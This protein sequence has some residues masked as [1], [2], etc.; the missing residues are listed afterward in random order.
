MKNGEP[1]GDYEDFLTG[2]VVD[3][4]HVWGRPVA[5]AELAGWIVVDERGRRQRDLPHLVLALMRETASSML[6][7]IR[8]VVQQFE[9]VDFE[10]GAVRAD[11]NMA[12]DQQAYTCQ[13]ARCGAGSPFI[14][15]LLQQIGVARQP[16]GH[17]R[18]Q[19][20]QLVFVVLHDEMRELVLLAAKLMRSNRSAR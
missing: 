6:E 16:G 17:G 13:L 15:A 11:Q 19:L 12:C 10:R 1:T 3:D 2:F 5:T 8:V 20:R 7:K 14:S 18:G 4:A 9:F